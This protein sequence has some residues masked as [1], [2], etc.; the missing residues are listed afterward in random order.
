[1][2]KHCAERLRKIGHPALPN[3]VKR[4]LEWLN[5]TKT[6]KE[7]EDLLDKLQDELLKLKENRNA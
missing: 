4:S 2:H 3:S 6:R 7:R 5:R 1:M